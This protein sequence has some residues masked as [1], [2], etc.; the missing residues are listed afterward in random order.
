MDA[1][2]F[3]NTL[4][5]EF[6][7]QTVS[8]EEQTSFVDQLGELVL[9]GVLIKALAALD[10]DH[11]GQLESLID[12]GKGQEEIIHFLQSSV[13]GFTELVADEIQAVKM[14]MQTGT[15]ISA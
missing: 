4:I 9:Q 6:S 3:R 14:D 8:P 13:P 10:N 15:G 7:L 2:T 1:S 12:E 11:A 5:N